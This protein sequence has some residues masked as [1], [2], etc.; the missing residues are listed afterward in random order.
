MRWVPYL[1]LEAVDRWWFLQMVSD[2]FAA[3]I[4]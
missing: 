2:K 4:E 3:N 1:T